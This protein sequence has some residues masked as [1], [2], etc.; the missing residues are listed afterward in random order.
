MNANL[1]APYQAII[2]RVIEKGYAASQT[3]VLR[4][5]LLAYERQLEMEEVMLVNKAVEFEMKEI[6]AGK[7]KTYTHEEIK[8]KLGM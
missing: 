8:K 3:E 5:A 4:Q 6:K 7:I 2:S 1:G